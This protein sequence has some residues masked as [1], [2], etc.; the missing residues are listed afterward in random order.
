MGQIKK[1]LDTL[2]SVY[3]DDLDSD[4]QSWLEQKQLEQ[5]AYEELLSDTYKSQHNEN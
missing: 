3:P 2:D 1:L 4:Y 5:A